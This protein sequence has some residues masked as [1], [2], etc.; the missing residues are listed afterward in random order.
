MRRS[1]ITASLAGLV[2]VACGDSPTRPGGSPP[3]NPPPSSLYRVSTLLTV[4]RS[5]GELAQWTR[6][7]DGD[8]RI[9]RI[10]LGVEDLAEGTTILNNEGGRFELQA[11]IDRID[12]QF[13]DT[14]YRSA[15]DE[16]RENLM[17]FFNDADNDG[18]AIDGRHGAGRD[19]PHDEDG[20]DPDGW[21][22]QMIVIVTRR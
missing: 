21:T 7:D 16:T 12:D 15:F 20:N 9:G 10:L 5:A 3:P 4:Y 6:G 14:D 13:T 19:W 17:R 18:W 22:A 11:S 1:F 8:D 2:L